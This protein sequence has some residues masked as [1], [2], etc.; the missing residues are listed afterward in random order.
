LRELPEL[1]EKGDDTLENEQLDIQSAIE[2]LSSW[3]R[4]ED[5]K[6][7]EMPKWHG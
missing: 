5:Q 2:N 7:E 1:S 3:K 6:P 4:P